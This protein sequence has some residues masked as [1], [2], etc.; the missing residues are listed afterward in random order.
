[1][2]G[3]PTEAQQQASLLEAKAVTIEAL[4]AKV[5]ELQWVAIIAFV[6]AFAMG[7]GL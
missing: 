1:M 4:R 7:W 3:L 2:N 6:V 5:R